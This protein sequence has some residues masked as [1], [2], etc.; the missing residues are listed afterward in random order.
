[1]RR[2]KFITLLGGVAAGRARAATG[3]DTEDW[4]IAVGI[5]ERHRDIG[6]SSL[7]KRQ[8]RFPSAKGRNEIN[9][10]PKP[11]RN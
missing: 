1:M 7:H 3:A 11:H 2:R 8:G 6:I 10:F 4:H 9:T 5:R